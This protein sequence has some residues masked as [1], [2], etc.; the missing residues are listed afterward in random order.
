M[1]ARARL[2]GGV[3]SLFVGRAV[4]GALG[5]AAGMV[6]IAKGDKWWGAAGVSGSVVAAVLGYYWAAGVVG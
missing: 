5:V 6:A 1:W 4:V 2:F 3:W